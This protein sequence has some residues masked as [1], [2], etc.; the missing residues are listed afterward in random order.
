MQLLCSLPHDSIAKLVTKQINNI[1]P[2][3]DE[4]KYDDIRQLIETAM[5]RLFYCFSHIRLKYYAEKGNCRFDHLNSDHYCMFL[6]F[7]ANTAY[8]IQ[9][10]IKIPTKLFLLNKAL[11]GL[12][13]FY[14]INLPKVFLLVHPVGTVIGNA[15]FGNYVVIYQNVTIGTS[16]GL[17]YPIFGDGIIFY[18]KSSVIGKVHVGNNVTFGANSFI[19]NNVI[20]DNKIV[21]GSY[22]NHILKETTHE[23][24]KNFFSII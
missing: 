10:D 6:Y 19:T 16:P 15:I 13:L 5:E 2:D 11:H 3:G 4:L 1:I 7:L 17:P 22:P 18:S 24:Y 12:D 8:H 20:T 9:V 21:I 14:T 23:P